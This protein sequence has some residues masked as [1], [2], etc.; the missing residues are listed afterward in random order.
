M[1]V[2]FDFLVA[3]NM[4]FADIFNNLT[5][6]NLLSANH[7]PKPV[8]SWHMPGASKTAGIQQVVSK[9]TQLGV[10]CSQTETFDLTAKQN[11]AVESRRQLNTKEIAHWIDSCNWSRQNKPGTLSTS[12]RGT[13]VTRSCTQAVTSDHTN[14]TH[15]KKMHL[16][17]MSMSRT[18]LP[19]N[20]F[21]R[22]NRLRNS[23]N[24]LWTRG[25]DCVFS[26]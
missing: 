3:Y 20:S 11:A 19:R 2:F 24:C 15:L 21:Q 13:T 10:S 12:P 5:Y 18:P 26:D 16:Q 6:V 25:H 23:C 7:P 17:E 22:A 14:T 1:H 4:Q 9:L 8:S